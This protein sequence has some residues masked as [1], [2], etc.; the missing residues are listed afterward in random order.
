M[1]N[2]VQ[3][4]DGTWGSQEELDALNNAHNLPGT[5]SQSQIADADAKLR[6]AADK[7]Y[8][9]SS[10]VGG[11]RATA[12]N[13]GSADVGG[14]PGA[15]N[16]IRNNALDGMRSGDA[17]YAANEAAMNGSIANMKGDRG[18]Q[19]PE[20]STLLGREAAT[21]TQQISGLNDQRI[22]AMGGA[23]S[24]ASYQSMGAMDANMSGQAGATGAARGLSALNGVQGAG[25]A[26][27]GGSASNVAITGGLSRSKE[28]ADATGMYGSNAGLVRHGDM[29]R[30]HEGDSNSLAN[31]DLNNSW[32]LGNANLAAKQ[33][34][35]GVDQD[36]TRGSWYDASTEPAQRQASYD[37]AMQGMQHGQNAGEAS[38]QTARNRETESNNRKLYGGAVAG[39]LSMI[40][41]AGP[42]LGGMA[43]ST[44]NRRDD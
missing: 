20:N 26:G 37:Q 17:A 43:G 28:I 8:S 34:G 7:T 40:P 44:I 23:P 5:S 12:H 35:L 2:N 24:A 18:P 1:A 15:G 31:A 30:L 39:G 3:F 10:V 38:A 41:V 42:A 6:Q 19:S 33:G 4:P 22:A 21:R 25:A 29:Q 32:K 11:D 16:D 9:G 36:R 27:V 13:P 14:S